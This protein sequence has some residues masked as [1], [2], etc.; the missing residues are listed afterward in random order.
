VRTLSPDTQVEATRERAVS[1]TTTALSPDMMQVGRLEMSL[2]TEVWRLEKGAVFSGTRTEQKYT[3]QLRTT[4]PKGP[5]VRTL[6]ETSAANALSPD[7]QV[8][9]TRERAVS[10]HTNSQRVVSRAG[11]YSA[12][13]M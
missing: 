11:R 7:T 13:V 9:A 3:V 2:D 5:A 4:L 10:Q 6:H 12:L 8:E 1:S